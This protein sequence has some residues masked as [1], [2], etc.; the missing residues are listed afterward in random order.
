MTDPPRIA[1]EIQQQLKANLNITRPWTSRNRRAM[2]DGFAAGTLT[3]YRMLGWG[4]DY[5]G[6]VQ[7]PR[8]PLRPGSGKKFGTPFPDIVAALNKGV[9]DRPIRPRGRPPTPRPTT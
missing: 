4:A 6:P 8:L 3:G 7:L 9:A 5:P 2:L 1:T